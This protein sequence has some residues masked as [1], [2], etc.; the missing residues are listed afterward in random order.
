MSEFKKDLK[1]ANRAEVF[2]QEY[3]NNRDDIKTTRLIASTLKDAM[4]KR[5]IQRIAGDIRATTNDGRVF[6]FEVKRDKSAFKTNN[7]FLE[8][9]SDNGERSGRETIGWFCNPD[10]GYDYYVFVLVNKG[11]LFVKAEELKRLVDKIKPRIVSMSY[12]QTQ[13]NRSDGYLVKIPTVLAQCKSAKMI[14]GL[15]L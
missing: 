8:R 3:L 2:I 9:M 6:R 5:A 14:N 7:L 1:L 4:N 11:T 15:Y 13:W 10:A 12:N